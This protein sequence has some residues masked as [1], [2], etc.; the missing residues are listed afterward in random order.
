MVG[1]FTKK[2]PVLTGS[3]MLPTF[4]LSMSGVSERLRPA[5]AT[6]RLGR[7]I[8]MFDKLQART[9]PECVPMTAPVPLHEFIAL[10]REEIIRRCQE[11]VKTRC[12]PPATAAQLDHGVPLFLNQMVEALRIGLRTSPEIGRSA[13]LHGHELLLQGFTVSQVVQ[14]YGD[15]CQTL[16]GLAVELN[17]PISTDDFRSLNLCLDEAVAG[18]LTEYGSGR[19]QSTLESESTRGSER[20]SRT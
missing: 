17:A 15:V 7:T 9:H 18:V 3:V 13:V 4:V 1:L 11:N 16:T 10:N 14:A 20:R 19:D 8:A 6:V 5:T 2:Q 12:L